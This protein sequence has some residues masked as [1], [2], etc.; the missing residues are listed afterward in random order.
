MPLQIGDDPTHTTKTH[1]RAFE[2]RLLDD[3]PRQLRPKEMIRCGGWMEGS[4]RAS[5]ELHGDAAFRP[6]DD[7]NI[8]Q[9]YCR[10]HKIVSCFVEHI[11]MADLEKR[12][13]PKGFLFLQLK[14]LINTGSAHMALLDMA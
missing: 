13:R 2:Q 3:A 12:S 11:L 1:R 14:S 7:T 10:T 6:A 4:M 9:N 5:Q 8:H